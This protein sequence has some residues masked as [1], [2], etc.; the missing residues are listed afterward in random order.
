SAEVVIIGAG[1]TGLSAALHLAAAGY[2]VLILESKALGQRASGLNGG[3]VIPGLKA[4]PDELEELLGPERGARLAASAAAAPDV[5]FELIGRHSIACDAI[6][7]GWIQPA[8]SEAALTALAARAAQWQRRGAAVEL[9]PA[10]E[11][12]VLT[13]SERY[14]GGLLDRRGG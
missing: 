11:V 13:G 14:C 5:V 6:R 12:R 4:D 9:L 10:H 2:A 7:T 8:T 3:Q 1:Y